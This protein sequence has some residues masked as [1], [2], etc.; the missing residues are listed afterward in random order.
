MSP[1]RPLQEGQEIAG[2][3][4]EGKADRLVSAAPGERQQLPRDGLA[5]RRRGQDGIGQLGRLVRVDPPPLQGF[6][7]ALHDH[8]QVIEIMRHAAGDAAERFQAMRFRKRGFAPAVLANLARQQPQ[9][10]GDQ[11]KGDGDTCRHQP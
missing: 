7:A 2:A 6:G 3:W 9:E 10:G 5:A 11:R 8:Q 4:A 1:R